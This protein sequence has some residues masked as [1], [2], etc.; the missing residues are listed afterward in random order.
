MSSMLS[1]EGLRR[2]FPEGP[3]VG[4]REPAHVSEPRTRGNVGDV[5]ARLGPQQVPADLP[6][7][8]LAEVAHRRDALKLLEVHE[9]RAAGN[10]GRRHEVSHGDWLVEAGLDVVDGTLHITR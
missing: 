6:Q 1:L 8:C 10:A 2:A 5:S 3:A 9:E 7:A 4:D